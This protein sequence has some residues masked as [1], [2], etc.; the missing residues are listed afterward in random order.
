[1]AAGTELSSWRRL[2]SASQNHLMQGYFWY[3]R[4]SIRLSLGPFLY[5]I[6]INAKVTFPDVWWTNAGRS[7]IFLFNR[8]AIAKIA[9]L[10]G[11]FHG[12]F[13]SAPFTSRQSLGTRTVY[14][15][16]E[17]YLHMGI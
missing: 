4:V 1:M 14:K 2:N 11:R 13:V 3:G 16:Q 12:W 17:Y 15:D 6:V 10:G 7:Q 5:H 9:A 8:I